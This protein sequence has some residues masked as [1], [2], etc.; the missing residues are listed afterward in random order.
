M[1]NEPKDDFM[2]DPYKPP[3]IEREPRNG[4]IVRIPASR[5]LGEVIVVEDSDPVS[6][7][8]RTGSGDT[9]KV[10]RSSVIL[11]YPTPDDM[12]VPPVE[13]RKRDREMT[14]HDI[15]EHLGR[16]LG[17]HLDQIRR[18]QANQI[19]TWWVIGALVF[20]W[21]VIHYSSH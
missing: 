14:A 7:T 11:A 1:G 17:D 19:M 3:P 8:I 18:L 16:Q 13:N 4:D 21:L 15:M 6:L 2:F 9:R 5:K 12:E 10:P 20:F